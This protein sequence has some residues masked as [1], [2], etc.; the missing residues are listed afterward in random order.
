MPLAFSAAC[1]QLRCNGVSSLSFRVGTVLCHLPSTGGQAQAWPRMQFCT[2]SSSLASP[3]PASHHLSES[4][5]VCQL[6]TFPG[7]VW[8]IPV[9]SSQ[10]RGLGAGASRGIPP[11]TLTCLTFMVCSVGRAGWDGM[12]SPI[13]STH[14]M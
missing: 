9:A 2:A 8:T 11:L 10:L 6:P 1:T 7:K 13:H 5:R 4:A 14:L 12:F 3:E